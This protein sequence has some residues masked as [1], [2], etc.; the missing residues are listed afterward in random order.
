MLSYKF[1]FTCRWVSLF[2]EVIILTSDSIEEI[3]LVS[4]EKPL[5]AESFRLWE[6]CRSVGGLWRI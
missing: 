6:I 4:Y 5:G 2:F 1:A 3:I